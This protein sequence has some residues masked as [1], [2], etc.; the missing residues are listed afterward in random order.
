LVCRRADGS[1][2]IIVL[3]LMVV[4]SA[5]AAGALA[6]ATREVASSGIEREAEQLR[7]AAEAALS[8]GVSE[9]DRAPGFDAV[10][11]GTLLSGYPPVPGVR[12][13]AGGRTVDIA[14][15]TA[16]LQAA[17]PDVG[18][19]TPRWVPW[20]AVS[21]EAAA[22]LGP[23]VPALLVVWVAD[24]E[25]DGDGRPD[26]DANGVV[27]VRA[28]AYG[29]RFAQRAVEGAVSRVGAPPGGLKLL[30]WQPVS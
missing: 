8:L 5:L 10:L 7:Y 6:L 22:P 2:L 11:A 28:A 20:V 14:A 21:L 27:R 13:V 4:V 15:L 25:D 17:T 23:A 29:P 3:V 19:N 30:A 16:A 12:T 9:L 18:L 1:V 26:V 24:D